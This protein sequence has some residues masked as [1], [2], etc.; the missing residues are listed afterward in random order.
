MRKYGIGR[1][2]VTGIAVAIAATVVKE[3]MKKR[4]KEKKRNQQI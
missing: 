2:I 1:N 4:E 3:Y